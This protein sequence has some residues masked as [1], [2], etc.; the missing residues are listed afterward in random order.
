MIFL[1]F[2]VIPILEIFIFMTI[3]SYIGKLNTILIILIT[4]LTGVYLVRKRG[5]RKSDAL[6]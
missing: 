3:G 1:A 5:I 4:A 6:T 2:V